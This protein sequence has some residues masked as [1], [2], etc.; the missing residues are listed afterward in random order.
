MADNHDGDEIDGSDPEFDPN[1]TVRIVQIVV[2]SATVV[3][4]VL[5]LVLGA[6]RWGPYVA[7]ISDSIAGKDTNINLNI[8]IP[9]GILAVLNG[10]QW[11]KRLDQKRQIKLQRGKIRRVEIQRDNFRSRLDEAIFRRKELEAHHGELDARMR[12]IEARQLPELPFPKG[13]DEA[14]N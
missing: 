14:D 13:P 7:A 10:V 4:V 2:P 5:T 8:V 6:D 3:L 1:S 11:K 9:G 12:Q